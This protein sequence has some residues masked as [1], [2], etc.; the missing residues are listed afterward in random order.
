M[1]ERISLEKLE[2]AKTILRDLTRIKS[3]RLAKQLGLEGHI[4]RIHAGKILSYL[5]EWNVSDQHSKRTW[6]KVVSE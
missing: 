3:W 4:G 1:T 6:Y 5:P 2:E